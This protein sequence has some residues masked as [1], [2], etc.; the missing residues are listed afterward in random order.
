MEETSKDVDMIKIEANEAVEQFFSRQFR[1]L[2]LRF[3]SVY[4][5]LERVETFRSIST[6]CD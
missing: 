4:L 3:Q 6:D 1:W 5:P 2:S